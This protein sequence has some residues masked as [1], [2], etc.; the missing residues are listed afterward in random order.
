MSLNTFYGFSGAT[1]IDK[2]NWSCLWFQFYYHGDDL[3]SAQVGC[4][5]PT[6][7]KS[8]ISPHYSSIPSFCDLPEH[9]L[10]SSAYETV[11]VN[12]IVLGCARLKVTFPCGL[13]A[14][15][16]CS[17]W[18][19]SLPNLL[20]SLEN[21]ETSLQLD[22]T[23]YSSFFFLQSRIMEQKIQTKYP[24]HCCNFSFVIITDEEPKLTRHF[25]TI[26]TKR[27]RSDN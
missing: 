22:Q 9:S 21:L 7:Q 12:T 20:D 11:K 18:S 24:I 13:K 15:W 23:I 3:Q 4:L 27:K 25:K 2:S 5:Q 14:M 8:Y 1:G 26:I 10:L 16:A 19:K 17:F 6:L